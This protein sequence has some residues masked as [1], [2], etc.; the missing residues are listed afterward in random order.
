VVRIQGKNQNRKE[1]VPDLRP[2]EGNKA[3]TSFPWGVGCKIA[4]VIGVTERVTPVDVV[5]TLNFPTKK[6][7]MNTKNDSQSDSSKVARV[8]GVGVFGEAADA[9][10]T[11]A[12]RRVSQ[13][14]RAGIPLTLI[15]VEFLFLKL[16]LPNDK[17][18]F[19]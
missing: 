12:T 11:P 5:L 3:R 18:L 16:F 4:A 2:V 17:S 6:K 15:P 10:Q 7:K 8:R 14:V 19:K 1:V 13:Q 9:P